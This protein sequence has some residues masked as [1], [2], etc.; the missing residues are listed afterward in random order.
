MSEALVRAQAWVPP[1]VNGPLVGRARRPGELEA[2]ERKAN[3]VDQQFAVE[4]VLVGEAGGG[5]GLQPV[6]E[7]Q[8]RRLARGNRGWRIVRPDARG[9]L[10]A[11]LGRTNRILRAAERVEIVDD[12]SDAV[13]TG[14]GA[15]GV[16]RLKSHE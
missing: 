13:G 11:T 8:V 1:E 4:F 3:A 12:C 14:D 9:C 16:D 2:I 6:L 10:V 7:V 5:Q 15:G